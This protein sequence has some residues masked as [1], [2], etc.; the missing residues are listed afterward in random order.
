MTAFKSRLESHRFRPAF[1]DREKK[2]N[3]LV[4]P[5]TLKLWQKIE[6]AH[7]FVAVATVIIRIILILTAQW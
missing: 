7:V 2:T 3:Y 6:Y 5:Q 4:L 1:N